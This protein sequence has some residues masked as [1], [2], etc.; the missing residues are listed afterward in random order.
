MLDD[1]R[2]VGGSHP[3]IFKV[4]IEWSSQASAERC[5]QCNLV[6]SALDS[7]PRTPSVDN[8][9]YNSNG[10]DDDDSCLVNHNFHDASYCDI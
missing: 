9:T 10:G 6:G 5:G 8:K 2:E 7:M 4:R 1:I 3:L